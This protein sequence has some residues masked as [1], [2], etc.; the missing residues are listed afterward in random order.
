MSINP[1]TS[2]EW[3][4]T[5]PA[6]ARVLC[7]EARLDVD[8]RGG[9]LRRLVVGGWDVLDGY[10]SG[11]VP[12][13]RRG[14]VLLPWP[15]RLR[16]G[17]WTW[18]GEELQLEIASTKRPVAMHGLVSWQPWSIL[19]RSEGVLSVGTVVEPRPGY[20]F[21]L[22]VAVDYALSADQLDVT[23][24]V[25]NA[26][27]TPAPFGAGMHPYFGVGAREDGG[28][29]EAELTLP[30]R[31]LVVVGDDG[32]P[33]GE[34][35]PFDGAV[36]RIGDRRFDDPLTDLAR[37]DDGWA[38][39]RLAGPAGELTVA[40]D[41]GWPWLQVYSGDTLPAG[42][43]RRSLAV[44]PMTCPPNA[45]ADGVDLV[46]LEPGRQWR[47]SWSVSWTPAG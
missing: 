47:S 20:P 16:D 27:H 24:R 22:A 37:D 3:P 34:T 9:G 10:P 15:N 19:D 23:L 14:H 44:E 32:L 17:R 30:A 4:A 45:L 35:R 26:G 7:D 41:E 38:R 29:A 6:E 2:P 21:R 46:V 25:G 40:V 13:G 42:E 43:R 5:E 1:R 28:L 11:T 12:N 18:D 31:T 8:L 33:T 39:V 36:G